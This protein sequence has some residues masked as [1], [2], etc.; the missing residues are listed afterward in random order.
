MRHSTAGRV[1]HSHAPQTRIHRAPSTAGRAGRASQLHPL[2][3]LQQAVGNRAAARIVQAIQRSAH[4]KH[5]AAETRGPADLRQ[6]RSRAAD[7]IQRD[8]GVAFQARDVISQNKGKKKFERTETKAKPLKRVGD[9]S[10]EVDTGSVMEFG[11]G[12]YKLWSELKKDLD[13]VS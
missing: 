8:I 11:T 4:A 10:M 12:H 1:A 13:A 6:R 9:L 5:T 3:C 7:V 2:L